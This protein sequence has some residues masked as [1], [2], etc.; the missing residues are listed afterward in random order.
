MT[1]L[2]GGEMSAN[3]EI[4]WCTH[5]FNPW[6]GC[7]EVSPACDFCY[8]R[9]LAN[10]YGFKVWG[11]DAPRRFFGDKHW[12]EPLKWDKAAAKAGV[13]ARVFCGSMCD[14]M[15]ERTDLD[16]H[17]ARLFGLIEETK[18]LDWLLLTKRP[19]NFRK[20]L[21]RHWLDS[22]RPNVWGMTTVESPAYLWRAE[23]LL[24][25][26]FAVRGLSMEPLLGPVDLDRLLWLYDET[27]VSR[28]RAPLG[29]WDRQQPLA[30]V[31]TGGES[32]S[33]AR[34][35]PTDWFRAIRDQ[36]VA[37][38]VAYFHKQNGEWCPFGQASPG[39][40]NA[41]VKIGKKKAGRLLDGREWSQ[42]PEVK[43]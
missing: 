22:P 36:C 41:L 10:R 35:T 8:A 15:E 30:W 1:D 12:A 7:V 42:F 28:M 23:A 31:I 24:S 33:H 6:W 13:R 34:P 29:G 9:T 18:N 20:R 16:E 38:N 32:G 40:A 11:K 14:V 25:T 2:Q 37:A 21:P 5:T 26:P 19:Q 27:G 43:P 17:R 39:H 4:E 3:S